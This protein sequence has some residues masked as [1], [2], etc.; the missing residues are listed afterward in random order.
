M[1]L[2]GAMVKETGNF[3]ED[4]VKTIPLTQSPVV[5][6]SVQ[7]HITGDSA[8]NGAYA[9]V[10][11]I[12]FASGANDKVFQVVTSD[13]FKATVVFG[14]NILGQSPRA[15]DNYIVTYRVGGGSRGN[16]KSEIVNLAL[17]ATDGLAATLNGTLTNTSEGTGGSDAETVE[18]A[19]RY[20]PLTFRRQD[21]VVTLDDYKALANTFISDYGTVGKA[22]AA[23]RR[24]FSSANIIDVYVLEKVDDH[25]LK[26]ATPEFKVQLLSTIDAKK[27]LTDE[28]II[29]DGL[30]RTVDLEVTVRVDKELFGREEEIKLK[31]RDTVLDHFSVDKND[32]GRDL[33]VADLNRAIFDLEDVRFS[34]VDNVGEVVNIDFNEI[35]LLL[36]FMSLRK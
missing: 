31:V 28:P 29:V 2:E 4:L 7:V 13:D 15:N 25:R 5:E 36:T 20:A 16:I 8:T 14:D 6:G 18:H 35:I 12:Y 23:V 22:T 17:T 19:K 27:M 10:E 21:R 26:K 24:A 11:N 1:L 30:I 32:F 33:V 3:S 34:S 9:E